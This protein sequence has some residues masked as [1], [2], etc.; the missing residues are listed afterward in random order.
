LGG[1]PIVGRL[2]RMLA[3]ND[4]RA[5]A[6]PR[7]CRRLACVTPDVGAAARWARFDGE[8]ELTR[9][10]EL[11]TLPVDP[12]ISR[13]SSMMFGERHRGAAGRW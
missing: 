9:S 6:T 13:H 8:L 4:V 3:I 2:V 12:F 7:R 11:R 1:R 5:R 10:F